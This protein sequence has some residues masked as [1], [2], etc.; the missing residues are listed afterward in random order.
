M[1][2][3]I[4]KSVHERTRKVVCG[5]PLRERRDDQIVELFLRSWQ[6]GRFAT[7][8]QWLPQHMA[9]VEV[10]ARDE[11]GDR[12]AI[13]HTRIFSFEGHQLQEALLRSIAERIEAEPGLDVPGHRFEIVFHPGFLD[14][15]QRSYATQYSNALAIWATRVLPQLAPRAESYQ[16]QVPPLLQGEELGLKIDVTVSERIA[17][18]R[19]VSVGGML[20]ADSERRIVP[21]VRKALEE[22]LPKLAATAAESRILL[23]ELPTID[24]S[25]SQIIGII[26]DSQSSY[27]ELTAV[28]HIVFARTFNSEADPWAWFFAYEV[29]TYRLADVRRVDVLAS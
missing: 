25:D 23:L 14:G 21:L 24:T 28:D 9:N 15:L 29:G 10:I 18:L 22:K 17:G 5:L 3:G 27:A 2:P 1:A 20:P 19:P 16:L 7:N 6:D 13:E 11:A 8:P 12:L 4:E 26:R